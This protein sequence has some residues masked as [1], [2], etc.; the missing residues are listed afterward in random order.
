MNLS[1]REALESLAALAS[2]RW[3]AEGH[4]PDEIENWTPIGTGHL[5]G[6]LEP[7]ALSYSTRG[8]GF[9]ADLR[10]PELEDRSLRLRYGDGEIWISTEAEA[11]DRLGSHLTAVD[12]E[13]ARELAVWLY[14]AAEELE[15][16]PSGEPETGKASRA[17]DP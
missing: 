6:E 12:A 3:A 15:R 14:Q 9:H 13:D 8:P 17:D 5:I 16:R 1:R 4:D 2:A 11:G 7:E 10:G